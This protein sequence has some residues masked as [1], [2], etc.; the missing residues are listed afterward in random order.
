MRITVLLIAAA[1]L[2]SST[3]LAA[4]NSPTSISLDE[5]V[6]MARA[7]SQKSIESELNRNLRM[8][9]AAELTVLENPT[10]KLDG[11][12][13]SARA[14]TGF[15]VEFEQPLRPSD[16]TGARRSLSNSLNRLTDGEAALETLNAATDAHALYVRAW[17]MGEIKQST[18]KALSAAQ[19]VGRLVRLSASAGQTGNAAAELFEGD[20]YRFKAELLSVS[21]EVDQLKLQMSRMAGT[22]LSAYKLRPPATLS[23]PAQP[24]LID[25]AY[26]NITARSILKERLA[27]ARQ[28]LNLVETDS[29]MPEIAPRIAYSRAP[30][31]TEQSYGFGITLRVPLWNTAQVERQRSRA[32]VESLGRQWNKAEDL[33]PEA[34]IPKLYA[35]AQQRQSQYRLLEREVIPRY[36]RSFEQTQ[37]MLEQGQVNPM[38]LWQVRE[39]L[40][41]VE[42][43]RISVMVDLHEAILELQAET[44]MLIGE[45]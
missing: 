43:S 44:G 3:A 9:D 22:D 42:L 32:L 1:F 10:V 17:A 35:A 12:K 45:R 21:T 19:Q 8:A 14:G 41:Q 2:G 31:D 40:N 11:E 34:V 5:F 27:A 24:D 13:N 6:T 26:R 7:Y 16:I 30:G 15:A 25:A 4:E 29:V 39:K 23:L 37:K 36:R 18:A 33:G 20:V 28:K 38:D